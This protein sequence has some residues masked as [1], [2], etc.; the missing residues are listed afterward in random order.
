M[1]YD[2]IGFDI[3]VSIC[4]IQG[5]DTIEETSK[6]IIER[7]NWQTATK[8]QTGIAKKTQRGRRTP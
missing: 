6:N 4:Q 5:M 2:S 8:D 1:T 3:A 7:L